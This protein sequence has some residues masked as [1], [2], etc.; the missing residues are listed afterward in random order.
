MTYRVKSDNYY[1]E[2]LKRLNQND[3]EG[4]KTAFTF[5][6]TYDPYNRKAYVNRAL[7][8]ERQ[9]NFVEALNDLDRA[10][11]LK[12]VAADLYQS[13]MI[14]E[15]IRD[16][17]S[18]LEKYT[19]SIEKDSLYHRAYFRRALCYEKKGYVN[20]AIKDVSIG[21]SF[22]STNLNALFLRSGLYAQAETFDLAIADLNAI[23]QLDKN[24]ENSVLGL[25]GY[26]YYILENYEAAVKDLHVFLEAFPDSEKKYH[27]L[28]ESAKQKKAG[29]SGL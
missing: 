21:L 17:D 27:D 18:A 6:L 25:R 5:A 15:K 8:N 1:L 23:I 29:N 2:G 12:K 11:S 7:A 10:N 20:K 24:R 16:F 28:L 26:Y 4:A 3:L 13:G 14:Y 9:L 19:Q 22:E